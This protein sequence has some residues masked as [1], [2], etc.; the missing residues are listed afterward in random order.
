MRNSLITMGVEDKTLQIRDV[1]GKKME[2]V[3]DFTNAKLRELVQ[4]LEQLSDKVHILDRRGL[5]F[6]EL[7]DNRKGG[8]LPTHWIIINGQNRFCYSSREYEE[9]LT[10]HD[11]SLVEDEAETAEE[12]APAKP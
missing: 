1:G 3:R 5:S 6:K 12:A 2:I 4:I 11:D 10:A 7:M 9:V 8:R